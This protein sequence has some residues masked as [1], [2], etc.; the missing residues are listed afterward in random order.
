MDR[1]AALIEADDPIIYDVA[2]HVGQIVA[3]VRHT[4]IFRRLVATWLKEHNE[5]KGN[6]GTR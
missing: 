6:Q 5:E 4:K 1:A 2:G 3:N